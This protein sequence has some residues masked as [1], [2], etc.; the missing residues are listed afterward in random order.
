MNLDVPGPNFEGMVRWAE[1]EYSS[2][3]L[4]DISHS[5][6]NENGG[7]VNI[8]C[9]GRMPVRR[10]IGDIRPRLHEHGFVI[11]NVRE[12]KKSYA[13]EGPDEVHIIRAVPVIWVIAYMNGYI[14]KRGA[15]RNICDV[16]SPLCESCSS[17]SDV[18]G[19]GDR[20]K[21]EISMVVP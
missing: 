16:D 5:E 17:L 6:D 20:E 7:F 14:C 21:D 9:P 19:F 3:R 10:S 11:S 15:C 18:P 8:I 13:D 12:N 4:V 2:D 1:R